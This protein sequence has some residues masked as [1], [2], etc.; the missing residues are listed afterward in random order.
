MTSFKDKGELQPLG[1]VT[2]DFLRACIDGSVLKE[3]EILYF[4]EKPEKW[5]AEHAA[6]CEHHQ[7]QEGE[8]GWQEWLDAVAAMWAP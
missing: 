4:L 3:D 2:L 8:P 6:W 7:P 1:G 5:A